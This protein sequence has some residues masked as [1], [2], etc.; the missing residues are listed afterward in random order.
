MASAANVSWIQDGPRH[1]F[2]TYR[3]RDFFQLI[4][5]IENARSNQAKEYL[6][7]EMGTGIESLDKNY[8]A[9][10]VEPKQVKEYFSV[11]A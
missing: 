8:I 2:V 7:M 10:G 6:N 1:S 11:A 3:N 5:Y 4:K 9:A